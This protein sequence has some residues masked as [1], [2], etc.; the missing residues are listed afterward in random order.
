MLTLLRV[1]KLL[2]LPD[3]LMLLYVLLVLDQNHEHEGE[4]ILDKLLD[5]Q[6]LNQKLNLLVNG[7]FLILPCRRCCIT[8]V[9]AA[10]PT[11]GSMP[12]FS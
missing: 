8:P 1:L 12:M 11:D 3:M 10:P 5:Q 6:L 7:F 4:N 9:N 2:V